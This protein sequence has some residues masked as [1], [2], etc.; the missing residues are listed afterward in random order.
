MFV[1][2]HFSTS[3]FVFSKPPNLQSH[4]HGQ[5]FEHFSC[6]PLLCFFAICCWKNRLKMEPW[7]NVEKQAL[8]A[9]K[10]VP[11]TN[12]NRVQEASKSLLG[13]TC[14]LHV[15]LTSIIDELWLQLSSKLETGL[16]RKSS[17][18]EAGLRRTHPEKHVLILPV[19]VLS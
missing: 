9:S 12:Q 18:L 14:D 7:K 13:R 19:F 3:P 15:V 4:R 10:M 8:P 6:F 5:C 11:K 1:S 17:K 16:R 2:I